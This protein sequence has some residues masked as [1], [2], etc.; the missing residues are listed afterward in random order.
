MS[1]L[2]LGDQGW[3]NS[4]NIFVCGLFLLCFALGLRRVLPS[5]KASF[6]GPRLALL[7]GV[8]FILAAIFPINPALGYPP[9]V[10][11][12]YQLH[13]L[14]HA[15]AATICFGCLSALCFVVGQRFVG[16]ADWKGWAL[17]SRITGVVVAVFYLL[18]SV[19][20]TLDMNGL[21]PDAPGGLLQ[22]ISI[23]SGFGWIM[24]LVLRLLRK[25]QPTE[26]SRPDNIG[27]DVPAEA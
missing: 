6:W 14:I 17:S 5:G 21:L 13:G 27:I 25:R 26:T 2:S 4:I 11:P 3:M 24:L 1:Q 12:T 15:L 19:V 20:T 9:G 18:A 16:D 8:L 22:R 23:I 10:A 7:C